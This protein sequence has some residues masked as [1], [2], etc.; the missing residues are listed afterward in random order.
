MKVC[1]S[2]LG[3]I[4]LEFY[5]GHSPFGSMFEQNLY[6]LQTSKQIPENVFEFELN[7]KHRSYNNVSNRVIWTPNSN[8]PNL[9]EGIPHLRSHDVPQRRTPPPVTHNRTNRPLEIARCPWK[10]R[11]RQN[12]IRM[13]PGQH[14]DSTDRFQLNF[15]G[16]FAKPYFA[17]FDPTFWRAPCRGRL[18]PVNYFAISRVRHSMGFNWNH[19]AVTALLR[20]A[21]EMPVSNLVI[22]SVV[23]TPFSSVSIHR[24]RTACILPSVRA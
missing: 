8:H 23:A 10:S 9:A 14:V 20:W 7:S 22:L 5:Y 2:E 15:P 3:N 17:T 13:L 12:P 16:D 24:V 4:L 21:I 19:L 11:P 6:S 1:L 18:R